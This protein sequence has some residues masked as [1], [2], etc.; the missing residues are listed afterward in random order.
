[1]DKKY[2]LKKDNDFKKVYKK[3]K[4]FGNR[5]YTLYIRRNGLDHSRMGF[6]INKKVG[7]AVVRN[8]IK[9]RLRVLYGE[10]FSNLPIGYDL[11][12]VVKN[13]VPD[14]TFGEMKSSFNHLMRVSK[15]IKRDKRS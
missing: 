14:M 15:M 5:N 3:R 2:F 11:V 4:T 8:K 10:V 6:S 1:M 12:V 13:N 9:R 7:K